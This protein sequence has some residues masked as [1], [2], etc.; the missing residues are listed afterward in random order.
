MYSCF[1]EFIVLRRMT[2]MP[3]PST[4][5]MVRAKRLGERASKS[6]NRKWEE[7]K[8]IKPTVSYPIHILAKPYNY[9]HDPMMQTPQYF[10]SIF[11]SKRPF[12]TLLKTLSFRLWYMCL[13]AMKSFQTVMNLWI[14]YVSFTYVWE[15]WYYLQNTHAIGV[16]QDLVGLIVVAVSDVGCSNEKLKRIILV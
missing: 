5:S 4:V 9:K 3:P 13:L 7:L 11:T 15:V 12:T 2:T 10:P 1:S 14:S 6:Y 16:S 8:P